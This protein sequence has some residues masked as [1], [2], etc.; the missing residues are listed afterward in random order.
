MPLVYKK[1]YK[2]IAPDI[3]EFEMR[4]YVNMQ[5][6]FRIPLPKETYEDLGEENIP[7]EE[8]YGRVLKDTEAEFWEHIEKHKLRKIK[9]KKV[10]MYT[11]MEIHDYSCGFG[12]GIKIYWG[13]FEKFT[14]NRR[15]Q[16]VFIKGMGRTNMA[17]MK[18][19]IRDFEEMDWSERRENFFKE[20]EN[21]IVLLKEK[22]EKFMTNSKLDE[23]IDKNMLPEFI[24]K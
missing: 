1:T 14:H 4:V 8:V 5:G 24:K 11:V 15:P 13:V 18:D 17:Y 12:E 16:Y 21:S 2:D 6:M 10:I 23:F 22:L 9:A 3:P 19:K 20:V 7:T